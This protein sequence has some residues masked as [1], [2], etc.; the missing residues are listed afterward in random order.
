M[1][2][3]FRLNHPTAYKWALRVKGALHLH[4]QRHSAC[5]NS[6]IKS[7]AAPEEV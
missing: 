4:E 7:S 2:Y 1:I 3:C 6:H 5:E